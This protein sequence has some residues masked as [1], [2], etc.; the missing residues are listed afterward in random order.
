MMYDNCY[1][2]VTV[3]RVAYPLVVNKALRNVP[4]EGFAISANFALEQM[5]YEA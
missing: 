1:V 3:E 2:I 5:Y 4:T